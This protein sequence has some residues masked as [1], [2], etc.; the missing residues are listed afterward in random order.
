MNRQR[1]LGIAA[2]AVFLA[3]PMALALR[4]GAAAD[5][6]VEPPAKRVRAAR[7]E[8]ADATRSVR[9][10][11]VARAA[12]RAELSFP[13]AARLAA[14]PVAV[15][16]A[17]AAGQVVARL[18]AGELRNAVDA[19]AAARAE[20]VANHRRLAED[21]ERAERL[22][23]ARAATVEE[24]ER[25][26]RAEEAMVAAEQ[27]ADSRLREARRRLAEAALVAPFAGTVTGVAAEPG[28]FVGT[29]DAV[30]TLSGHGELEVEVGLPE[31][32]AMWLAEGSPVRVELPLSGGRAV[33]GTI[34]RVGR[35]S[36]AGLFPAVIGLPADDDLLAGM[37][38]EVIF[39]IGGG[40]GDL[41]TV[42][43]AAVLNPGGRRPAVFRLDGER[44]ARV[45]VEV[46]TLAGERVAVRGDLEPGSEVVVT[47]HTS[48]LDGDRVEVLR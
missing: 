30:V 21:R 17:V 5:R 37:T 38:A 23:A 20:I 25:A 13:L 41:V 48:L 14:R 24:V 28:E 34:H 3:L 11:G 22:F 9:F 36:S 45:E 43:L 42:P 44:V 47:G 26:R 32:M 8:R 10:A 18:D 39:E 29:G 15:G 35:A 7:V 40:G 2:G 19:A 4:T 33:D 31:S 27:A 6:E 12:E 1:T 46:E 16:E